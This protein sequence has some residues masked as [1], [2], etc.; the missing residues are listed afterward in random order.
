MVI[1]LMT[2]H[3]LEVNKLVMAEMLGSILVSGQLRTY[4]SPNPIVTLTY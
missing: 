2:V 3:N 1:W 4:P